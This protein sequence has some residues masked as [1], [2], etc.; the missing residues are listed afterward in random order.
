V[1]ALKSAQNGKGRPFP[2]VDRVAQDD[3]AI[4]DINRLQSPGDPGGA[5]KSNLFIQNYNVNYQ[6]RNPFPNCFDVRGF[7]R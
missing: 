2:R 6:L 3:D 7:C 5:G 1:G 4:A